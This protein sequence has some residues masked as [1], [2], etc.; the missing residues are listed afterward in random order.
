MCLLN[1]YEHHP[2]PVAEGKDAIVLWDFP[3]H[4]DRTIQ[5]NRPDIVIKDKA[6]NTCL[7]VNMSIP[8]DKNVSAKVFENLSK[9]KDLEI[10]VEKMWH[11]KTKTLPV[12][13]G[14]LSLIKKDTDK[15]LEQIPG[16]PRL[17]EVQKIV[18]N[19]TAHILRRVLSI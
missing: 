11:L 14:A 19:S 2:A 7:F 5:A 13:I 12:V 4:T 18:L 8:S 17:E 16:N 9:Y 10:E 1:W 6:N 15:F 3:I